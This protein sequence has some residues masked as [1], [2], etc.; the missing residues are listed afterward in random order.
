MLVTGCSSWTLAAAAFS[1]RSTHTHT[2]THIHSNAYTPTTQHSETH[3]AGAQLVLMAEPGSAREKKKKALSVFHLGYFKTPLCFSLVVE[4]CSLFILTP[5]YTPA[6]AFCYDPLLLL[7]SRLL[8]ASRAPILRR[9][10]RHR[11]KPLLRQALFMSEIPLGIGARSVQPAQLKH[12]K[13]RE[14]R[15]ARDAGDIRLSEELSQTKI[16]KREKEWTH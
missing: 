12:S 6:P 7:E 5:S 4:S 2:N 10:A 16:K 1:H 8:H 13:T 9:N 3:R 14:P 11:S 15:P